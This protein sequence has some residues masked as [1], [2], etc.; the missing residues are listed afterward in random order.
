VEK[1]RRAGV[2][3]LI[4][5]PGIGFGKSLEHNLRLIGQLKKLNALGCPILV[6]PSRKSFIGTILDAPVH[7]RLEGSLAS[8]T[9]CILNGAHL[10]RVHDVK[11]TK[12]AA[13]LADAVRYS[14]NEP[15]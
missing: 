10:L 9:A 7:D 14:M 1:G 3:Q 15:A 11:E 13:L 5:D 8:A 2:Q 4:V 12:R 6:G